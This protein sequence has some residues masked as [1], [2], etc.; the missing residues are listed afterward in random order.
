VIDYIS[1][2]VRVP[3][4]SGG[5]RCEPITRTTLL[6]T[7]RLC[8]L[9]SAGLSVLVSGCATGSLVAPPPLPKAPDV[10]VQWHAP[11]PHGGSVT[12]LSGWWARLGDDT[13]PEL[14]ALAQAA[15][16]TLS[17]A[18]A[19]L[20]RARAE[21]TAGQ[22]ALA[23]VLAARASANR[24][25]TQY[26]LPLSNT[27]SA[28]LAASWEVDLF[29]GDRLE[30]RA[31]EARAAGAQAQW[32]DARV[33]VAAETA[34]RYL[35]LRYCEAVRSQLESDVRALESIGRIVRLGAR[36]GLSAAVLADQADA[37]Q[38]GA[39]SRLLSQQA[40]CDLEVKALV[41]L[42]AV[43][44]P[45]LRTRLARHAGRT[46]EIPPPLGITS[47]PAQVIAQR[48]DVFASERELVAAANEVGVA[49][50][51]GLPRLTLGGSI[52]AFRV[53]GGPMA[54]DLNTWSIGP[55]QLQMP[56]FDGGVVQAQTKAARAN[57]DNAARQYESTV[58]Q[59]IREVE[60]AMVQAY[61]NEQRLREIQV[62]RQALE[63]S[64]RA[65]EQRATAGLETR[66]A[67]EEARRAL[68]EVRI[69]ELAVI[70][71]GLIAGVSL[72]RAAGGGWDP[73]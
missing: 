1:A 57:F 15:S 66:Q 71:E 5:E 9:L 16:P 40:A 73:R 23:P 50:A 25:N 10:P 2:C 38:A 20:E 33:V 12:Q 26:P 72:Y 48:P 11:L 69:N 56:V 19:R 28:S 46:L 67:V 65:A 59:A 22:A 47:L 29:G 45:D 34:V 37:Q 8:R 17:G 70:R 6:K 60:E 41:A 31:A 49:Q 32:H 53:R 68:I 62:A 35:S 63:R 58:R 7:M 3:P 18:A 54:T 64:V 42:T 43:P 4:T 14:I 44:E 21:E 36:A 27:A 51:L 61:F 13:L 52:G 30:L 55:L 24:G 39:R